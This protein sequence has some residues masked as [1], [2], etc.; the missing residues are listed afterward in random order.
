MTGHILCIGEVLWDAL[1]DGLFLGGAPFNVACHLHSLGVPTRFASRVGSD[2][3]GDE[4]IRRLD[5][6]AIPTDLVQRD[7]TLPTGFVVVGLD[8]SGSPDFTIVAPSAWDAIEYNA[9]LRDSLQDARAIVFGSL[10]QRGEVSRRTIRALM[11]SDTFKVFDVNLR[12]PYDTMVI[13]QESLALADLVK[14]NDDEL[15][16]MANWFGFPHDLRE[17]TEALAH[18]FS[19]E[20]V[21][22]T[23]GADGA[24]LFHAGGWFDH[25][26][27][28]VDVADTV[29]SGDAFLAAL[30]DGLLA[31]R[32]P[33]QTL[34]WANAVGAWVATRNGATPEL[35]RTAIN[36]RRGISAT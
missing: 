30:L 26:G 11:E 18:H 10:A 9:K 27:Y 34:E 17:G 21:C 5:H 6:R 36:E 22:V 19:C 2:Q 3:L 29:G 28:R 32:E 1:P 35:D 4:I 33:S 23:R 14:L 13:V 7:D 12:S 8:T 31:D 16:T 20:T 24:A 15:Q 25:P